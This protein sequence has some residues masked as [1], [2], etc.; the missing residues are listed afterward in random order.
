MGDIFIPMVTPA[1]NVTSPHVVN[2][3]LMGTAGTVLELYSKQ[4]NKEKYPALQRVAEV[5]S[6]TI[7]ALSMANFY[8]EVGKAHHRN[9]FKSGMFFMSGIVLSAPI[10][11]VIDGSEETKKLMSRLDGLSK[12]WNTFLFTLWAHETSRLL[13]VTIVLGGLSGAMSWLASKKIVVCAD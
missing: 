5:F 1:L 4:M 8:F 11:N 10:L 6:R 13:S 2:M 7:Q 3:M 9:F 12:L